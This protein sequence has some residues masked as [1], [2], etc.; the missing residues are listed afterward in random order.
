MRSR[1]SGTTSLFSPVDARWASG[2]RDDA[3]DGAVAAECDGT[4]RPRVKRQKPATA[5]RTVTRL[6]PFLPPGPPGTPCARPLPAGFRV[7]FA[8]A[9]ASGAGRSRSGRVPGHWPPLSAA[10]RGPPRPE[11]SGPVRWEVDQRRIRYG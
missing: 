9:R 4:T 10:V 1:W 2:Q 5:T 8:A 3:A 7:L 11:G 6:P